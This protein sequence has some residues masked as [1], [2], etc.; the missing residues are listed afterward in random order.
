MASFR[1]LWVTLVLVCALVSPLASGQAVYTTGFEPPEFALGDVAGQ[2]GWGHTGNSHTG[3]DIE[4]VPV[5]SPATFGSQSLEIYTRNTINVGVANHLYSATIDPSAGETGSTTGGV[6]VLNPQPVFRATLWYHTPLAPFV[7]TRGDGRFA[8]LNPSSKGNAAG[9]LANR[10]AQVRIFN[11]PNTL[12]GS[13]A[14]EIRWPTTPITFAATTVATLNWN[15]WYRFEYLIH[16]ID[17]MDGA[18]A[19]DR[20][21][22]TVF[23]SDGNQLGTACGTTWEVGYKSGTYGGGSTARAVN[24]FDFFS[25]S[26]PNGNVAGYVDQLSMTA[27]SHGGLVAVGVSGEINVCSGGNTTL[28]ASA[29]GGSGSFTGYVWR[30]S[31]MNVVGTTATLVAVAG[32]YTVTATDTLCV[33]G[34]TPVTVTSED[35]LVATIDG[36]SSVC[37]G[38]TT[39]LTANATGGSGTINAYEWRNA[40]NAIVGTASTLNAGAGTYTVTVTDATCGTATSMPFQVQVTCKATPVVNWSDPADILY[41]TPLSGTQLNA[42]ANVPGTFIYSPPAGTILNAG[43]NQVLTVDFIPD[44]TANY[45]N[46]D[47]TTVQIDV[48]P[49]T[50]VVTVSGGPYTYDGAPHPATAVARDASSNPVSGTF[51]FTYDGSA[52]TPVNAGTYAVIA[53]FTSSDP[54]FTNAT[55][56]GTLTIT[57]ATP[58]VS[59]SNPANITYGTPLGAT[60]LNATAN[61]GGTFTYN[62][63]AG[64]VLN[65]GANQ[66]LSVDFAPT[67]ATNYNP[68]NGTTV[69]ITVDKAPTTIAITDIYPSPSTQGEPVTISFNLGGTFG[70][71]AGTI[72][73]T[74][75]VDSCTAPAT[76]TSCSMVLA[77]IGSRTFTATYSGDVNHFGSTSSRFSH[78]VDPGLPTARVDGSTTICAGNT[79]SIRVRFTGAGPWTITWSDGVTET[80]SDATHRREVAPRA[81]ATYSIVSVRDANGAGRESG[82]AT[83]TVQIV[84]APEILNT[85]VVT[86]LGESVTLRATPG[87]INYQWFRDGQL[88]PGAISSELTIAPVTPADLGTYTVAGR[89]NGCMSLPS[90]PFALEDFDDAVIPVVGTVHGINGSLFRTTVHLSNGTD[91]A[92]EGEITFIDVLVPPYR[93]TLA[94]GETRFVEDLLPPSFAGLTSANVRRLVGPLPVIVV[95]VFNDEGEQVTTGMIERPIPIAETLTAGDRA[96]LITPMDP[97]TTRFSLGMR[98]LSEGMKVR[99]TRRDATGFLLET[100]DRELGGSALTHDLFL[101]GFSE[102]LTFDILA[103]RGVIYG[104]ATDNGTNDPNMQ[105]ATKVEPRTASGRYVLPVAGSGAGNFDS[106]FATGLQVHNPGTDPLQATLRFIPGNVEKTI[107]VEPRAT[108]AMADVVAAMGTSGFG[109]LE[110]T[111]SANVAPVVLAR[112]YSIDDDGQTSLMTDL[113]PFEE[114]LRENEEALVVAPHDP[115]A[116]RFN[117]GLRTFDEGVHA[118]ATVR[119]PD[120]RIV[121]VI[122]LLFP[123]NT[124]IQQNARDLLGP[125]FTGD[126]SVT[127]RIEDGSAV[128]YGVWTNNVTQDPAL[129]YAVRPGA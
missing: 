22:L 3:G 125:I 29:S 100:F 56:N 54:N 72:T 2:N 122:A 42:T 117:I 74:D 30:D 94:P 65:A 112:I 10:Y 116:S 115:D 26:G 18:N 110:L 47:D 8:E 48:L 77:T 7:S 67:D 17:G 64:T 123:A 68:V 104:A 11:A 75:G 99:V 118:T 20:F 113:V 92:I 23:D 70:T 81:T 66:T 73:V 111:T 46:V 36:A 60:Q 82:S 58:V 121:G 86:E 61:V 80:V 103:G 83:V 53:T 78:Q 69:L 21:T 13:P 84:A 31:L 95:H 44:D 96:V 40:S 108:L 106:F 50:P 25:T 34:T 43:P 98:S 126:E 51:S 79:A 120:G 12:F 90:E 88:I 97:A 105:I 91:D 87:Y 28:T 16:L 27:Q 32:S 59:W 119:D 109:S 49:A 19:N 24:G 129:Q 57:R 6:V 35:P 102:S 1:T 107:T 15:E 114:A 33:T 76:A 4:P 128:I 39:T 9:D 55:G 62:P 127:F 89:R 14:V 101:G 85:P 45:N 41:G 37:F 38:G 5:G 93:Y 52:A 63:P 124:F 71:P